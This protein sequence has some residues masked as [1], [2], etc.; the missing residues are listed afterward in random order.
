MTELEILIRKNTLKD[1]E[2]WLQK[3]YVKLENELMMLDGVDDRRDDSG[4]YE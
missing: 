4:K 2:I 3:E 1:L